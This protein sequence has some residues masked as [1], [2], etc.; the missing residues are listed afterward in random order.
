MTP[1]RAT[2]PAAY[3]IHL[4]SFL[5]LDTFMSL[6]KYNL[7]D[8][9]CMLLSICLLLPDH[10]QQLLSVCYTACIIWSL[11]HRFVLYILLEFIPIGFQKDF[12]S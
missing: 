9:S 8:T 2:R 12:T 5:L 3:K 11:P 6:K 1:A 10:N 4:V 7:P